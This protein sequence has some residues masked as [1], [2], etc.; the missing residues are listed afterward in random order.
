MLFSDQ[1]VVRTQMMT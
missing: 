1:H